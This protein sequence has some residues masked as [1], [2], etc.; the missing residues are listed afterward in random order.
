MIKIRKDN[1][2]ILGLSDSNMNRLPSGPLFFNMKELGF[3]DFGLGIFIGKKFIEEV[4]ELVE[5]SVEEKE[6]GIT[7]YKLKEGIAV[8]FTEKEM[9]LLA[10]GKAIEFNLKCVK[11]G[12][13]E[14]VIYNGRTEESMY[15]QLRDNISP[16]TKIK[17]EILPNRSN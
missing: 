11:V 7:I 4:Y 13:I 8:E 17:G 6:A 12:D 14:V 1:I 15:M 2:L 16:S 3:D 10:S 5:F 9:Q